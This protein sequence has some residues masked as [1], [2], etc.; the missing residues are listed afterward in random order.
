MEILRTIIGLNQ[1]YWNHQ[2]AN[3]DELKLIY[4]SNVDFPL[5]IYF[6]DMMKVYDT[7]DYPIK[8]ILTSWESGKKWAESTVHYSRLTS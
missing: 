7:D 6:M 2:N 3:N 1:T 4:H 5:C 8:I